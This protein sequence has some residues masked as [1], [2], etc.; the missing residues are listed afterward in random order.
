VLILSTVITA[1]QDSIYYKL[2]QTDDQG[3]LHIAAINCCHVMILN[4]SFGG[5]L[6]QLQAL[7]ATL[8]QA[9]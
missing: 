6:E 5:F 8:Q 7:N 9:S 2:V 4:A 3:R 1:A